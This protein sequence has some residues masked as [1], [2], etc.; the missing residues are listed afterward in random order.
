[1]ARMR[2]PMDSSVLIRDQFKVGK[3]RPRGSGLEEIDPPPDSEVRAAGNGGS[4]S[5]RERERPSRAG[6]AYR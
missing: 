5:G 1:M 2:I 4:I 3:G 6:R